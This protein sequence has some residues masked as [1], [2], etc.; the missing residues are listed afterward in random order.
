MKRIIQ[1]YKPGEVWSRSDIKEYIQEIGDWTQKMSPQ[2]KEVL[3]K[4][5]LHKR[6]ELIGRSRNRYYLKGSCKKCRK[7]VISDRAYTSII[8]EALSRDPD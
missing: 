5:S 1:K 2:R 6:S 7:V 3:E 8:A 4:K